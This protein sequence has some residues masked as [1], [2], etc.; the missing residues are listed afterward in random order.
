MKPKS[1]FS[2]IIMMLA[3]TMAIG[4]TVRQEQSWNTGWKFALQDNADAKSS[5]FDDK[6]WRN[7]TLPHDW[8]IDRKSVV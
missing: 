1:I 6:T 8:S 7:V 5:N 2:I 3:T 4:Q